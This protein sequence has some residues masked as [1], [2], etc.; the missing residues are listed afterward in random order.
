MIDAGVGGT[1]I[2]Q[3]VPLFPRLEV[4]EEEPEEAAT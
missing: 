2:A 1:P 4:E 3:P